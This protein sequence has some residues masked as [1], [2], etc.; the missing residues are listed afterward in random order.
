ML[1]SSLFVLPAHNVLG[2]I[3]SEVSSPLEA[4]M[5]APHS[6]V[7]WLV[8]L[9][10]FLAYTGYILRPQLPAQ[11]ARVF[12]LPYRVLL[13]KY[14][15]DAFNNLVFVRGSKALGTLFYQAGDQRMIDGWIVNGSSRMIAFF[16]AKGRTIQNGYLYH[17]VAIM[18]LGLFGLLCWLL[19]G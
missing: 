15:F 14:G 1:G 17:Y 8:I 11:L 3:G 7:F 12:S 9:G 16:A 18:V 19:L 2:E 5:H 4:M 6:L 13:N 10:I